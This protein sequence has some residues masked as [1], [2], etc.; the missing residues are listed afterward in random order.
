[1][2]SMTCSCD[3]FYMCRNL[4]RL[5]DIEERSMIQKCRDPKNRRQ[6]VNVKNKINKTELKSSAIII[7]QMPSKTLE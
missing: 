3:A 5:G 1:M 4:K 6:A 7:H 2:I